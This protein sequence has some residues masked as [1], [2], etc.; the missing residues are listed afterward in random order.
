MRGILPLRLTALFVLIALNLLSCDLFKEDMFPTYLGQEEAFLDISELIQDLGL[1][2]S[3]FVGKMRPVKV[4]SLLKTYIALP[5][6]QFMGPASLVFLDGKNLSVL[7]RYT[8]SPDAPIPIGKFFI[9]DMDGYIVTGY[10]HNLIRFDPDTL[11]PYDNQHL[12]GNPIDFAEY[13]FTAESEIEPST[14]LFGYDGG[15]LKL[16]HYGTG[17]ILKNAYSQ[18]GVF[19]CD[20]ASQYILL[21]LYF[22]GT[23]LYLALKNRE[24]RKANILYWASVSDFVNSFSASSLAEGASL[25]TVPSGDDESGWLTGKGYMVWLHQNTNALDRYDLHKDQTLLD[26]F[27]L[28]SQFRGRTAFFQDGTG[29]LLYDERARSLHLL[30]PWW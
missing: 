11:E 26:G 10:N 1:S 17:W 12:P 6:Y 21:D 4:P 3:Y 30:R 29:W 5:L 9:L 27:S 28:P 19:E 8:N 22:D 20:D 16:Q 13:G 2:D 24:T 7:K 23:G 25:T 14:Y 15:S 18:A